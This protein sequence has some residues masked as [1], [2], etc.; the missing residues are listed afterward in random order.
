MN[1][2]T[3]FLDLLLAVHSVL[4]VVGCAGGGGGGGVV[5]N[6]SAVVV[7]VDVT[8]VVSF[9]SFDVVVTFSDKTV[10]ELFIVAVV[11]LLVAV[12][13]LSIAVVELSVAVVEFSVVVE[14]LLDSVT[15]SRIVAVVVVVSFDAKVV[16]SLEGVVV[17]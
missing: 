8:A 1:G 12:V 16:V 11:E 6:W 7:T 15:L 5:V 2:K 14:E 17:F 4:P 9:V 10:V 3:H 13:E